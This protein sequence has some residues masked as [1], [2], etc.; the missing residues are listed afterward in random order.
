MNLRRLEQRD[1]PLM[2]EWMHDFDVIEYMQTDFAHKTIE[3]CEHFIEESQSDK[4]NLNLAVVDDHNEYMGTVSLKNVSHG[5]A[6]FAI[7]MR[8]SAMGKG[9]SKFGMAAILQA[10]FKEYKL[11]QVY[12]CV[13]PENQRAIR[14]YDKNGYER[15]DFEKLNI[16]SKY[17]SQQIKHYIWYQK[18]F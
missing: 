13:A 14:F 12:W 7:T 16:E 6:E 3:D 4:D 18:S 5:K 8:K 17:T 2:L 1:A 9:F 15:T 11:K 10:A